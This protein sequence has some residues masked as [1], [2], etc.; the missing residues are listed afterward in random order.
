MWV[1]KGF[2]TICISETWLDISVSDDDLCLDG[3][4]LYRNDRNRHSGGVAVFTCEKIGI[5]QDI[6]AMSHHLLS[7]VTITEESTEKTVKSLHL[8]K[9]NGPDILSNQLLKQSM[10]VMSNSLCKLFNESLPLGKVPKIWKQAIITPVSK[11]KGNKQ[12]K[13]NYRPISL[14]SNVRK[15]LERL[16]FKAV[17]KFCVDHGLLTWR[18]SGYKPKDSTINQLP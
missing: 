17:Y 10:P 5:Y 14:L 1:E 7:S 4:N 11:G 12:D 16:V 13:C 15:L 3:Y 8:R 2:D 18:N 6:L 9:A